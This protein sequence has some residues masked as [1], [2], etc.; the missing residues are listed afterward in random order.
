MNNKGKIKYFSLGLLVATLWFLVLGGIIL[1]I[2]SIGFLHKG[3]QVGAVT[4]QNVE[5]MTYFQELLKTYYYEDVTE[6]ELAD[7]VLYGL[8]ETVGDPYTCYYSAEEMEDLTADIEGIFHGIG[9]YLEMDYDA[10]YAKIS[11][12]IEG[13]PASQ[14]DIKVGDYVVKV[15]GVD[16]YEMTLTDVV[17]MIRGDAGTQVVLTLNRG[18]EELEVTVTRQNIETPTVEYELLENDIAYITVTE[19]DDITPAQFS[20]ALTQMET[21]NAKGLILDLRGNPGGSLAAVVEMCEMILPEGMIVYTEDK[22]GQRSE[23]RCKGENELDIPMVVLIDGGSASASEIMAGAI[24]DYGTGT[25]VGTT[26]YGKGV[27]QKIFTYEDGSAAKITVSKYYTPNGYNIHGV[28]IEPDVEVEF[29]ADLYLDEERDNQLE[30]A[31]EVMNEK[32]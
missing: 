30:K 26:T 14:S 11:G 6:E 28:G 2:S 8:M 7:G 3:K 4:D 22:Y 27:V 13:T 24:K 9:A 16:T 10:G 31:I 15:D 5:K 21:D 32:L 1:L 17:A 19:F 12:I 23:Y 25:L 18:G 29:D 20:E